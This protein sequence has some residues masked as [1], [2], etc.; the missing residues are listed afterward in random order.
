MNFIIQM[1][2]IGVARNFDWE[3]GGGGRG[4]SNIKVLK[5]FKHKIET[6]WGFMAL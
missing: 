5:F 2:F 4:A 1:A 6:D 3:G